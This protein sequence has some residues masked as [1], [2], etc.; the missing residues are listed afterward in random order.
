MK[1]AVLFITV[2]MLLLIFYQDIKMRAVS[3]I[4]FPITLCLVAF[5]EIINAASWTEYFRSSMFNLLFI[6][7]M[8]SLMAFWFRIKAISL[9]SLFQSY[10]GFGDVLFFAVFAVALPF[11]VF[12]LVFVVSLVSS[13]ILGLFLFRN[14][15]VPLAGLQAMVLLICLLL[16]A[17]GVIQ[18]Q[19]FSISI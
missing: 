3:W 4:L 15:T 17:S 13:L 9:K 12:P 19:A 14:T 10:L 7:A 2:L 16:D 1:L 8:L 5:L 11:P 18:F 6:I